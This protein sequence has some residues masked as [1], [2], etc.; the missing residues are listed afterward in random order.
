MLQNYFLCNSYEYHSLMM[1]YEERNN[2]SHTQNYR[3]HEAS[4]TFL[5]LD[6]WLTKYLLFSCSFILEYLGL[7]CSRKQF[8]HCLVF[9]VLSINAR[10]FHLC[11]ILGLLT[12]RFRP[13]L[14]TQMSMLAECREDQGTIPVPT[15][16]FHVKPAASEL[17]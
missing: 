14:T 12:H 11:V 2:W 9:V 13:C 3:A 15:L 7:R 1:P 10:M 17:S 4:D 16:A 5:H 8:S 6:L